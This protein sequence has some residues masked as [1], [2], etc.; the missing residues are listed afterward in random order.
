MRIHRFAVILQ[1]LNL[2][3]PAQP[4]SAVGVRDDPEIHVQFEIPEGALADQIGGGRRIAQNALLIAPLHVRRGIERLPTGQVLAIEQ[5][6]RSAALPGGI[7]LLRDDRGA[8][9]GPFYGLSGAGRIEDAFQ[10][11]VDHF[12]VIQRRRAG[13]AIASRHVEAEAQFAIDHRDV[14]HN[15]QVT[16]VGADELPRRSGRAYAGKLEPPGAR[17]RLSQSGDVPPPVE[18]GIGG[19]GGR[20]R[21]QEGDQ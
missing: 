11:P 7:I 3:A 15:V 20:E 16:A 4:D 14:V 9:A 8:H 2:V 6:H 18:I 1:N 5:L 21:Q 12:G 19:E 10:F 13:L 17:T